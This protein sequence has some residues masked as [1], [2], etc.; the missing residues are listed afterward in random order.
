MTNWYSLVRL[1][2]EAYRHLLVAKGAREHYMALI[3]L[4][5][6]DEIET[7]MKLELNG[8]VLTPLNL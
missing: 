5:Q 2:R 7:Q 3:W 8:G 4:D 1:R 6:L